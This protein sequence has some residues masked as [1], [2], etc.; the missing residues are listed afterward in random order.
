[1]GGSWG[2]AGGGWVVRANEGR[3][4][5]CAGVAAET[6]RHMLLHSGARQLPG[7]WRAP[8]LCL[9]LASAA[10]ASQFPHLRARRY[11][12]AARAW[13]KV[14]MPEELRAATK[15]AFISAAVVPRA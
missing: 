7:F 5:C 15:R 11:D 10:G 8:P 6:D 9:P 3:Q 14:A 4:G 12:P 13:V 1:M 2:G